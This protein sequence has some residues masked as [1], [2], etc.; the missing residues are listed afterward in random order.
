MM[1]SAR[2][3]TRKAEPARVET[4]KMDTRKVELARVETPKVLVCG[5][6]CRLPG[7]T[8]NGKHVYSPTRCLI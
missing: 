2:M 7:K 8:N 3:D 4:A 1:Q 6:F 5:I